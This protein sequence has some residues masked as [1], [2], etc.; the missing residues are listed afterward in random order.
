MRNL[1]RAAWLGALLLLT[2]CA[3]QYAYRVAPA[4]D[5]RVR[6]VRAPVHFFFWGLGE[7]RSVELEEM[8]D[9]ARIFEFGSYMSVVNWLGVVVT[10]GVYSPR[11]AYAVCQAS[12]A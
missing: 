8:C 12:D 4:G 9:R 6:T 5:A 7:A 1:C 2:A 11:T 10:L 3:H